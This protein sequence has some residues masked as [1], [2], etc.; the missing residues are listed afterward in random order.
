[1]G[2][3]DCVTTVLGVSFFGATEANP[4]L[5]G[6]VNSNT[7]IFTILKLTATFCIAG[8]YIFAK[9][10]LDRTVNQNTPSYRYS[11]LF[12]KAAYAG[13]VLFMLAV[14]INNLFILMT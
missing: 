8:T 11:N 2:T 3:M 6:V 12:V 14:L 7:A 9:R 10:T 4:I 13:I 1:M 5:V